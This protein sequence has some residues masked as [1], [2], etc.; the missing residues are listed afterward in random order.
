MTNFL[1]MT[2]MGL[3][4]KGGHFSSRYN[5][6]ELSFTIT[7]PYFILFIFHGQ[8]IL[9]PYKASGSTL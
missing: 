4:R 2:N 1:I 7:N 3:F 5:Y 9:R 6:F 8:K